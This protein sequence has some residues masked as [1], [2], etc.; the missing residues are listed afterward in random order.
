MLEFARM[1][2]SIAGLGLPMGLIMVLSGRVKYRNELDTFL[3]MV[4]AYCI[5]II[6]YWVIGYG[7][8]SGETINGLIG[9]TKG[10]MQ[11]KDLL[12]GEPDLHLLVLFSVPPIAAAAGM[13]ERG[14]FHI[15][16]LL[17][18]AVAVLVAPV[19][20][21]WSMHSG[22]DGQGWLVAS[23]FEDVGGAIVVFVS[24][25]FV[26]LAISLILGPRL[27]RFP[28]QVGRPRGQS[29][30]W[31]G[32]GVIVIVTSTITLAVMQAESLADMTAAF[33]VMLI[34]VAFSTLAGS[35]LPMITK[36]SE[37]TQNVSTSVLAGTVALTAVASFA[38]PVDAALI[39]I[40]AGTLSVSFNRILAAIEVD[41]PGE[42]ISAFLSGGLVGGLMA[43]LAR[44]GVSPSLASEFI[45]QLIGISAIAAWAFG[46]TLIAGLILKLTVGLRVGEVEEKRGLSVSHFGFVS[47]PDFIISSVMHYNQRTDWQNGERNTRLAS[48]AAK[49][50][51][52][53]VQLHDATSKATDRILSTSASPKQGA[54][55]VSRIR[56]AEDSV[57]VKAEDI[58]MLLEDILKS[59]DGGDLGGERFLL[60][61][62]EAVEKLLAPVE[63]DIKKLA[64]HI[65][66]Q[67]ELSELEN[68]VITAAEI[69]SH[70]VHQIEMMRDLEEAQVDGFF[71]RDHICDIAA[72]LNEKATR[73]KAIAEVR[74]RPL[75]I[76]CAVT[77]GLKVSGDANAFARILTLTVEGAFNRQL[78]DSA[79]PV[80]LELKE[81]S[82]GQ[83]VVLD[84]LDT[85]TA[86]SARQIRAIRDPL[87]EDRALDEL[88][89]GQIL[90]LILVSRLVRAMGGEFAI[91]SA[92]QAGTQLRCRF[93]KRQTKEQRNASKAA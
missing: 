53:I 12:Q 47:E 38:E 77:K 90:P 45:N 36:R 70:G 87:S 17:V 20:A 26:G 81:H 18:G 5:S 6:A 41:D 10:F 64:R 23:G 24:A 31:Y 39:G 58:L 11:R 72:L 19:T 73:I 93:R 48:I 62:Q 55:M 43:P 14:S 69:L 3:R 49:F 37:M 25:G 16:N 4:S 15:G 61:G 60:W 8:Y 29:P 88:G 71:S 30:T 46:V 28:M 68:I 2:M 85:G 51:D 7:L 56:L 44:P 27:G 54:A 66:L 40:L 50:S 86:L 74:N 34:G 79:S 67:A 59:G 78:S 32:M 65:P 83:Y 63:N 13:V 35:M 33:Y 76:D 21:H 9:S 80:R 42:L 22:L 82:S 52:A 89:L 84:C 57:R 92:H 91:T 1:F 75:Q